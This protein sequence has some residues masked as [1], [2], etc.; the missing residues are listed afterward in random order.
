MLRR[1][2]KSES[3]RTSQWRQSKQRQRQ[4]E[5]QGL[6]LYR[7]VANSDR[8]IDLCDP[9]PRSLRNFSVQANDAEMMRTRDETAPTLTRCCAKSRRAACG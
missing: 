6:R 4:R 8:L 7:I 2:P 3:R 9:N 5:R 1:S